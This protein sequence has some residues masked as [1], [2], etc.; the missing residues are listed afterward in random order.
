MSRAALV[1][2]FLQAFLTGAAICAGLWAEMPVLGSAGLAVL[3]FCVMATELPALAR[4]QPSRKAALAAAWLAVLASP[5]V[6]LWFKASYHRFDPLYAMLLWVLA[7]SAL[8]ASSF[9]RSATPAAR[10]RLLGMVWALFVTTFLLGHGHVTNNSALFHGATAGIVVWILLAKAWFKPPDFAVQ[11]LNTLLL[12]FIGVPIADWIVRPSYRMDTQ[13]ATGVNYYSYEQARQNPTAFDRWWRY[14]L[15]QWR[16]MGQTV[17]YK[18][19]A[20]RMPFLLRPGAEAHFFQS[21]IAINSQGFRGR[22]FRREKGDAYRIVAIGESTTF[23]CTLAEGDEPWPAL[24]EAR[25]NARLD[26]PRPVEVINAGVPSYTLEHNL[27]RLRET[28][29]PLK[30]DMLLSYHGYNGFHMALDAVPSATGQPPPVYQERPLKLLADAEY[31][32]RVM[33]YRR[34]HSASAAAQTP[35]PA[36]DPMRTRYAECHREL[37]DFCR[38]NGIRLVLATFSMAVNSASER[39]LI[40]FYRAPFPQVY[41]QIQANEVLTGIIRQTASDNPEIIF[42][43]TQP[44]LDGQ[45]G[46]YTDLVHF[47][48]P[49]RDKMSEIFFAG[50]TN[51]LA[52][53]LPLPKAVAS[54]ANPAEKAGQEK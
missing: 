2:F 18:D 14:Y 39:D 8:P 40:E 41:E 20:G 37:A 17:F 50:I 12:V 1:V 22:E 35:R 29:L 4:N 31:R 53:E 25:I 54:A 33:A 47:T 21:R 48:Q 42:V 9:P 30:P 38:T 10:L 28:L 51:V 13:P 43:D 44:H 6:L 32:A 16:Q 5:C 26:P 3:A 11:I 19:P 27:L 46:F 45:H 34:R 49:G 24:L 7:A 15:L 23:G 52:R 36:L